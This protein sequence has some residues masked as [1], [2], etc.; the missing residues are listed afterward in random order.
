MYPVSRLNKARVKQALNMVQRLISSPFFTI[1]GCRLLQRVK[2]L[3][4]QHMG[5][6]K[7]TS[8]PPDYGIQRLQA[9][10][11]FEPLTL[12][13]VVGFGRIRTVSDYSRSPL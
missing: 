9:K 8:A 1:F 3:L 6:A 12:T 2:R 11:S 5:N 10:V 7:K 13:Q 4:R